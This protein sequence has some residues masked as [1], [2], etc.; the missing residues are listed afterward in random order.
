[1]PE[2]IVITDMDANIEYVN[3]A[4]V[5]VT[6]Y[7]REDVLGQ[8]PR[9]LNSGR[10]PKERHEDLWA[11][12][13]QGRPWKGE[14]INR[15]KDGSEY[16][17][18]AIVTPIREPDGRITHYVAVKEDITEKKRVGE[19]LDRHRHQLEALVQERTAQLAEALDRAQAASLAKGTFLANMSHEIRTPLNAIIGLTNLL[20]RRGS[21]SDYQA[22]KLAKVAG[23]GEHL[24]ALINNILDLSRIES[25]KLTL[26]TRTFSVQAMCENLRVLIAPRLQAKGLPLHI[27]IEALPAQLQGDVTRLTQALLNYL[28]NAAKFT[29]RGELTLRARVIE[30]SEHDLRVRFA[31][32]DTGIGLSAEQQGRLFT[33]FEQAD[34]TTTRRFG[35]TGLGLAITRHLARLMGGEVGVESR[36]G[37]GSTF[38]LTARLGKVRGEMLAEE[39]GSGAESAEQALRRAHSGARVLLVEDEEVNRMVA[40]EFLQEAGLSVALAENGIE[41]VAIVE[42]EAYDLILMD[43]QMPGMDGLEATRWIRLLPNGANV[44]ILA[45]TA[46]AFT[47]D[48]QACLD[49]GMNDHVPKPV[50]AEGLYATLLT[51]LEK[52]P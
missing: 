13:T 28:G 36:P 25:G 37:C 5:Q 41:A 44:P 43:V 30:E 39:P 26:E 49:A 4:F 14:F 17:E 22:D 2:S 8:N 9:V 31:V 34:S 10:T 20:Q 52:P 35:G 18:F 38:W 47:E 3:E 33:A 21:L 1:S 7:A 29:E 12:L 6:G 45:M 51:Y 42:R 19:E 27:D 16:I 48:R 40:Q 15:R 23:A 32:E 11:A 50:T 46:N 24:L